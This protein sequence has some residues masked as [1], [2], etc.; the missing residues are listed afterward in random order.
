MPSP[1]DSLATTLTCID[2]APRASLR[3]L[4]VD[5]LPVLLHDAPEAC[6]IAL[7]PGDMLFIELQPRPD[8]GQRR[9]PAAQSD[10]AP[11]RRPARSSMFTTSSCP[12]PT[13][14]AW[15][16]RGYNEQSAIAALLQGDGFELLFA[17]HYVVSR[18]GDQLAHAILA[19]LPTCLRLSRAASGC[20]S[21]S[22]SALIT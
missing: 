9:R 4:A 20:K 2:P 16:W 13:R 3:G 18:H 5:W 22:G 1:T 21:Y 10:P 7:Q 12:I 8:A 6:F 14:R 11:A 15:A 17:S 19:E